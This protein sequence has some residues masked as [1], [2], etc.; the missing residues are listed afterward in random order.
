MNHAAIFQ[1]QHRALL[2]LVA[3]LIALAG[4]T[5]GAF[6]PAGIRRAI[7]RVLRPAEAAGR[8]L[9][10]VTAQ[11]ISISALVA[12]PAPIGEIPKGDGKDV[13]SF[14]LFDPRKRFP[15]I[16]TGASLLS[17]YMHGGV[18]RGD[19]SVPEG[20]EPSDARVLA[21][22]KSL[23]AALDDIPKEARRLARL[24][25]KRREADEPPIRLSPLRPSFP[26][27][28]RQRQTHQVDEILVECDLLARRV[29]GPG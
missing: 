1:G 23:H 16:G 29:L 11:E 13:P 15:E 27:G 22:L 12:R 2:R 10:V 4:S 17:G 26:P 24:L 14:A 20:R 8:R 18:G 21:R 5:V 9:I 3:T 19:P 6:L 28:Y 7:L 25:A